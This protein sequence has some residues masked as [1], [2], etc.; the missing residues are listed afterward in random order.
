RVHTAGSVGGSTSIVATGL[1]ESGRFET[2]LALG[3]EIQSAANAM[4]VL[5]PRY[6]FAPPTVAGAGGYFSPLA[7]GYMRRSGAPS[8]IGY[9]VAVKDRVNALKNPY[10]HLQ[11]EDISLKKVEESPMLWDPIRYLETCPS[12]DG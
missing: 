5:S 2:V 1:I 9:K 6:P 8:S 7:R 4:W 3:F 12:S 11:I 10:A